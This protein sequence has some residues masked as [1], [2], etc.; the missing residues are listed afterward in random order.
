MT[1]GPTYATGERNFHIMYHLLKAAT[2]AER[3]AW[4][5]GLGT[6][7]KDFR[8]TNGESVAPGIDDVKGWADAQRILEA[9]GVKD[10]QRKELFGMLSAVLLLGN[11]TFRGTSAENKTAEKIRHADDP[12]PLK[13]AAR[14]LQ[15]DE[16]GLAK[17]I[18]SRT[19]L[20]PSGGGTETVTVNLDESQCGDTR[21]ALAK[22][23]YSALFDHI[24]ARLNAALAGAGMGGPAG[25]R[26]SLQQDDSYSIGL[27][28]I[29]GFENFKMNS[30]E[31]LCINFT[32]ERLQQLFMEALIKREQASRDP[33][34]HPDGQ[35]HSSHPAT[36]PSRAS[37]PSTSA[38]ASRATTSRTP[39]TRRR[40]SSL[41]RSA[42]ASSRCS[43]TSAT[44]RTAPTPS[45]SARCTTRSPTR[46]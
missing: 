19:M 32:N 9:I 16:A 2:N 3:D 38:R 31:Q 34:A 26:A 35:P 42:A 17:N 10:E 27:L 6:T 18:A 11:L 28:D 44:R 4:S 40:S 20:V 8:Y 46:C 22:A 15:I 41:T 24:V 13:N 12:A 1:N 36:A 39:T 23:V 5:L 14:L 43:T 21:D 29:F 30:F 37:R 7:A 33:T 25:R 45:S